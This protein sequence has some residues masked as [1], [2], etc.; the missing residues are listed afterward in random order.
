M[1]LPYK[2]YL[3]P[4]YIVFPGLHDLIFACVL[5]RSFL[6]SKHLSVLLIQHHFL[7]RARLDPD[8]GES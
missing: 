3:H 1:S 8:R 2:C 6:Q 7:L 5:G 4:F